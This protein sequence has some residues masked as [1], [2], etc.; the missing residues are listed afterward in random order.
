MFCASCGTALQEGSKFCTSCGNAVNNKSP[1][2][3]AIIDNATNP[4]TP[5]TAIHTPP[6]TQAMNKTPTQLK[7]PPDGF[8]HDPKSGLYYITTRAPNPETGVNGQWVT[9]FYPE[10]KQFKQVFTADQ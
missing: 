4:E 10:T 8:I 6:P 5:P 3:T 1:T 7:L 9:W 2:E